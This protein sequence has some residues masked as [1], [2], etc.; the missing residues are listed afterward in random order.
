MLNNLIK[1]FAGNDFNLSQ[2][3]NVLNLKNIKDDDDADFIYLRILKDNFFID[4][5]LSE[6]SIEKVLQQYGKSKVRNLSLSF[7]NSFI[8]THIIIELR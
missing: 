4:G 5:T 3:I 8:E 1:N 6:F 2:L 7:D